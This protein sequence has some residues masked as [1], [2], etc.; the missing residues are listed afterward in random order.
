MS[1]FPDEPRKLHVLHALMG[2]GLVWGIGVPEPLFPPSCPASREEFAHLSDVA[3]VIER[4][5]VQSVRVL[6]ITW[7]GA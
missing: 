7:I 4:L 1:G 5:S 3:A 6:L 2:P